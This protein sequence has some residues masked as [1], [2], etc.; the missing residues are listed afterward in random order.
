MTSGTFCNRCSECFPYC[1]LPEVHTAVNS[2]PC[3]VQS[4]PPPG[5]VLSGFTLTSAWHLAPTVTDVLSVFHTADSP[6]S[7]TLTAAG[8]CPSPC[9][10]FTLTSAWHLAPFCSRCS[11]CFPSCRLPEVQALF[12]LG[13]TSERHHAKRGLR[14]FVF[15]TPKEGLPDTSLEKPFGMISTIKYS[16]FQKKPYMDSFFFLACQRSWQANSVKKVW[17]LTFDPHGSNKPSPKC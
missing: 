10:S 12:R 14:I 5:D 15:V 11:E 16:L 1:R 8:I 9:Y 3:S 7:S 13:L 6:R 4:A 2:S 17:L